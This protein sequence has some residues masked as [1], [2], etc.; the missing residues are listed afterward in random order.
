MLRFVALTTTDNKF[1]PFTNFENWYDYDQNQMKYETCSLLARCLP[2]LDADLP[3][4]LR[5]SIREQVIDSIIANV[6]LNTTN[7]NA[8]YKKVVLEENDSVL[9]KF[10]ENPENDQPLDRFHI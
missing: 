7:A 4:N 8:K 2:E 5:T 1:D 10:Y 3:I 6:P 9:E